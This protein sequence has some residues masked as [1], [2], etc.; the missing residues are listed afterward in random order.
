MISASHVYTNVRSPIK[1]ETA[2]MI[3]AQMSFSFDRMAVASSAAG[4]DAMII[5]DRATG[6][7]TAARCRVVCACQGG[8]D[9][10]SLLCVE[11]YV[12]SHEDNDKAVIAEVNTRLSEAAQRE[13]VYKGWLF[14]ETCTVETRLALFCPRHKEQ[15]VHSDDQKQ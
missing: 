11:F 12:A 3:T 7:R 13:A 5:E 14:C 15:H 10:D 6:A 9:C 4:T 8:D 2:T 1:S